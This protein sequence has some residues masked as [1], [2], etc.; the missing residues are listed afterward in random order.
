M[1]GERWIETGVRLEADGVYS[2]ADIVK[3]YMIH[4]EATEGSRY[5]YMFDWLT[6]RSAPII[7]CVAMLESDVRC[8]V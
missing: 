1:L 2:T 6:S 4:N 8:V 7:H 5:K 3:Q